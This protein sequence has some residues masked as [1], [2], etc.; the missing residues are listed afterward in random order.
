MAGMDVRRIFKRR[1]ICMT[2]VQIAMCIQWNE[3]D[4]NILV[5]CIGQCSIEIDILNE[6]SFEKQKFLSTFGFSYRV[7][8][9]GTS[10]KVHTYALESEQQKLNSAYAFLLRMRLTS[11][12]CVVLIDIFQRSLKTHTKRTFLGSKCSI[13][14]ENVKYKPI[15]P[16]SSS[17]A[18]SVFI[19]QQAIVKICV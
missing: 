14:I 13:S 2:R 8:K 15:C 1:I 11:V 6:A 12:E 17:K 9:T 19:L 18:G 7:S 10:F 4:E 16:M 5:K 3:I